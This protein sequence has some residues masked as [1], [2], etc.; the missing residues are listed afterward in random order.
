MEE[1]Q[2]AEQRTD[3]EQEGHLVS[4]EDQLQAV[5][6]KVCVPLSGRCKACQMVCIQCLSLAVHGVYLLQS[7]YSYS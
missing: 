4:L 6:M 2:A 5:G 3:S 7:L 1:F